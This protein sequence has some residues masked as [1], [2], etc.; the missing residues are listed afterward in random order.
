MHKGG[1][2]VGGEQSG[3]VIISEYVTTGDG[4]VTALALLDVM[5]RSGKPLSELAEVMEVYPQE[6]IK[7]RKSTR[8][9]SSH[10]NISYAVFC[11]KKKNRPPRPPPTR[12]RSRS[13][14]V[15]PCSRCASGRAALPRLLRPGA[16]RPLQRRSP[17]P[18][19]MLRPVQR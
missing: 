9:N 5:A 8:L 15:H 18:I 2:S 10:A 3:H 6:L 17:S 13:S 1:A 14:R 7:D 19:P 4:L 16:L 11:L 12:H